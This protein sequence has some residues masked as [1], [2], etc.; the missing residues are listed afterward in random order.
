M[1]IQLLMNTDTNND[2]IP[3]TIVPGEDD[4][5]ND[6]VESA[7]AGSISGSVTDSDGNPIEG[8][9]VNLL[10]ADGFVVDTTTTDADGNYNFD[11]VTPGDYFVQEI[12]PDGYDNVS[13]AGSPDG[14]DTP[15]TDTTDDLIPVTVGPGEADGNNDFVEDAQA[16][17]IS[18]NVSD[19]AGTPLEGVVINLVDADG[20][21]IATTTTDA[22]G[23]YSFDNVAPGE[24]T[25][26][27][28]QPD[29]Y[30]TVSDS[31]SDDND[32]VVNNN[33][34]DDSIPVTVAPG[35][36]DVNNDYG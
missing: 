6:F 17:S 3:V 33:T 11:N 14:N 19:D 1:A 2:S 26:E 4:V 20:V 7:N 28:V 18:G 23:N 8:V 24:Y 31:Q 9:V 27:E 34:M 35:E 16:G 25:V 22:A 36:D 21:T 13:D 29:N 12:Q 15:N 5:N 32:T 30:T 10:D